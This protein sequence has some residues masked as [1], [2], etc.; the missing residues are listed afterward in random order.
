[1]RSLV[2]IPIFIACLATGLFAAG[3]D[4]SQLLPERIQSVC[5][6]AGVSDDDNTSN[7]LQGILSGT[8]I[9]LLLDIEPYEDAGYGFSMAIPAGWRRIVTA[10]VSD[11]VDSQTEVIASMQ[12][13]EAGFD[14]LWLEPGYAVGFESAQQHA[15]D[16]FADYIL[17]EILPGDASGLFAA[18]AS[19]RKRV[20]I[21]GRPASYD[22][23]EIKQA[24][25][26]LTDVDLVIYQAE[27]SG[28]GYTVGLYSIG[29]R[30]S[31]KIMA[32]AFEVMLQTFRIDNP[33]FSI[34]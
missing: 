17:V 12:A 27:L 26:G 2:I 23:L 1:M 4:V 8:S 22:R 7:D 21:D 14:S 20:V 13:A 30:G 10:E 29:E 18:D 19:R 16:Q 28:V 24:S 6:S 32:I 3:V 25:S 31:E 11:A 33:P 9:E 15:D 5:C 34:S